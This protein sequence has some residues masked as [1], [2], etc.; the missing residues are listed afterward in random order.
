[1]SNSAFLLGAF[2]IT[3]QKRGAWCGTKNKVKNSFVPLPDTN[4]TINYR[5][6][7]QIEYLIP[8]HNEFSVRIVEEAAH[9]GAA[10]SHPRHSQAANSRRM[11]DIKILSK[12]EGTEQNTEVP[13]DKKSTPIFRKKMYSDTSVP[14]P[15][16]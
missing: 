14:Y 3:L 8:S 6:C 11:L 15:T 9:I 1:M 2:K 16:Y 12:T 4:L 10:E 13:T 5:V 7:N